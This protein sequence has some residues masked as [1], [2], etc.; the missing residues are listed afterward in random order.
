MPFIYFLVTKIS[1]RKVKIQ[2]T[3]TKMVFRREFT[4]T[5]CFEKGRK[6]EIS[7]RWFSS[8]SM[9]KFL[10]F[11]GLI[12]GFC[13]SDRLRQVLRSVVPKTILTKPRYF[14]L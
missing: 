13:H 12:I 10:S 2:I 14:N 3:S 9:T 6:L 4:F 5:A 8:L 1:K 11:Y 7:L